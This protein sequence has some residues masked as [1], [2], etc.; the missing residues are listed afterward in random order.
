MADG[1]SRG[2]VPVTPPEQSLDLAV[3]GNGTVGMLVDAQG[4]YVWGCLPHL[5]ADPTFCELLQPEP[6]GHGVCAVEL[7]GLV[8]TE[9]RYLPNTAVLVTVL[10]AEDGS[11][12]EITDFAPRFHR[13][14][15]LYHPVMYVRR[16]RPLSGGPRVTHPGAAPQR[17]GRTRPGTDEWQP[18]H[19]LGAEGH[20]A[21]PDHRHPSAVHRARAA[22]RARP[23]RST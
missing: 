8:S 11:A 23:S 4:R 18:P 16:I 22:V 14:D 2:G 17:L 9:Q 19:P 12:V 5:A 13:W 6:E 7:E 1:D 15:R 21:S 3:I 20:D 10:R